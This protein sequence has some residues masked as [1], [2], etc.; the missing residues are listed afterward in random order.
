[1]AGRGV[2]GVQEFEEFKEE[3]PGARIQELVGVA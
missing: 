2:Q 1:M 3:E